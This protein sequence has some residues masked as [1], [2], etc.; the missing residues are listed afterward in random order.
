MGMEDADFEN[1]SK[2]FT[3]VEFVVEDGT[4]TID[5][6]EVTVTAKDDA[7]TYGDE[8]PELTAVVEGLVNGDKEDVI[9]YSITREEGENVGKYTITPDGDESQ[10]NYKVT[11]VT[12][13]FTITAAGDLKATDPEDVVYNGQDQKQPVTVTDKNGKTLTEGVDYEITYSDDVKNVGQV[14]IT[15]TATGNYE[16]TVIKHYNITKRPITIHTDSASKLY[17]GTALTANDPGYSIENLAAG[18]TVDVTV[19]GSQLDAGSSKNT[20]T[21]KWGDGQTN[22]EEA[23]SLTTRA[24]TAALA[25]EG[26]AVTVGGVAA[27]ST[28][29]ELTEDIGT[30]TVNKR[31]VVL[32]SASAT[33]LYNGEALTN[34][35]VTVGGDGFAPGEGATFNVT[36]TITAPGSVQ[37]AFTYT[38]NAGTKAENYNITTEFGTLT[39]NGYPVP[40]PDPDPTPVVP[41][42]VPIV[43]PNVVIPQV[44]GA[45]REPAVLGARRGVLGESRDALNATTGDEGH[46]VQWFG[47]SFASAYAILAILVLLLK[48]KEKEEKENRA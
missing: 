18:E 26:T 48:K 30:L 15:I 42:V 37:N 34:S 13:I 14:T 40:Q 16:G 38:L 11:Y 1:I 27:L 12:G 44:L 5:Q 45:N 23:G 31:N 8:D 46:M 35:T 9:K 22:G 24:F 20:Y 36:G 6:A 47:V 32:T 2:N 17:D 28:N 3:N 39:V 10:G 29:Y 33:R 21:I 4:L 19:T 43:T 25:G 41:P 7:K